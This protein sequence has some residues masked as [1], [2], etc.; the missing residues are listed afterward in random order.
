[1]K[2]CIS[3]PLKLIAA[4]ACLCGILH[5]FPASA[6]PPGFQVYFN[7]AQ[8]SSPNGIDTACA[9]FIGTANETVAG[10]F[11][12]IQRTVIVNALI[13]AATRLGTENVR[14][15]TDAGNRNSTGCQRL[16]AAGITVIDETCDGWQDAALESH[17]KFCVIDGVKV[18]TGSYN[19][20]DS[21]SVYNNNNALA[22]DCPQLAQEYL[23][24][25]NL[26]W[27]AASGPPGD[28]LFSSHK[29][30]HSTHE[31]TCNGV[32]LEL[33]FSPT[34]EA[35][36]NRAMDVILNIMQQATSSLYFDMFAFT[37]VSLANGLIT[38][39]DRGLTVM[40]VMDNQQASYSSSQYDNLIAAGLDVKL[41]NEVTPHG[42]FLHHKF[43]VADY[44]GTN[45]IV[46]TGSYNWSNAAQW[47]NDEN[48]LIIHDA[49]IA[50]LYYEE[51]YRSYFG[52]NPDNAKPSIDIQVNQP[53]FSG[54]SFMRVTTRITNPDISRG[55]DEYI[56]LDLGSAFGDN[57][58]FFW[59]DWTTAVDYE[60][61]YL[62]AD[63]V[64][65]Q[66]IFNFILPYPLASGGPFTI[67]AALL[68]P[69]TN[70]LA[71][72]Y[73]SIQFSFE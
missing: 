20:T 39:D 19:I 62:G 8:H 53:V 36:P 1:M 3:S 56:I 65:D 70:T 17:N 61:Q 44:A 13:D 9:E 26:M 48:S 2:K 63:A 67:W 42:N 6:L 54:G 11:Y 5:T 52:R 15:I 34:K 64:L 58:Y 24:E 28:C 59:P 66:E 49:E 14:I 27:G 21:D 33:Y 23:A 7:D 73:D 51:F 25:F 40:G 12:S 4:G 35:Y 57:Q 71:G 45:P 47:N 37:S 72:D 16:E 22:I 68:D 55:L 31:F 32:D 41:D 50:Y 10:A 69:T 18:W 38:A 60:R 43:L 30:P 46:V 29:T